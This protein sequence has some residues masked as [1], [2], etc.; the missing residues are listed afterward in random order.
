M[1]FNL[2][3]RVKGIE[4]VQD[5]VDFYS[6]RKNKKVLIL[7]FAVAVAIFI[8]RI[9]F[10][11]SKSTIYKNKMGNVVAVTINDLQGVRLNLKGEKDGKSVK[12]EAV[13]KYVPKKKEALLTDNKER[14]IDLERQ[15]NKVLYDVEKSESRKQTLPQRLDDGTV[16]H[17]EMQGKSLFP[18]EIFIIPLAALFIYMNN[19][20]KLK[21]RRVMLKESMEI[22]L[23]TFNH[24]IVLLLN[25]GLIFTDVI[26]KI[27]YG[28]RLES[29]KENT[30]KYIVC[31]LKEKSIELNL[32][33]IDL[34]A[35]YSKSIGSRDFSRVVGIIKDNQYKGVDLKEKLQNES[36]ML[37][38][39][40]IKLAEKKGKLAETKL[41]FPLAILLLVLILVTAAPAILKM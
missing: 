37:W 28:Y 41:S 6:H 24:Q 8:L 13:I 2:G 26:E 38:S 21:K 19:K 18:M 33:Y 34:L 12:K 3:N 40:R 36:N 7:I 27:E 23:P 10:G 39:K 25:A 30:F 5:M 1:K 14:N 9:G 16:L 4:M 29:P 17:W 31:N 11:N 22:G 32:N 35:D 20:E 15:I